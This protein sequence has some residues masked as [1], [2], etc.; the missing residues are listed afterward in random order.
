MCE[1]LQPRQPWAQVGAAGARTQGFAL[2]GGVPSGQVTERQGSHGDRG[3]GPWCQNS[4][5][6]SPT[7]VSS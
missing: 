1:M 7:S 2:G 6:S 3:H 5:G 4:R